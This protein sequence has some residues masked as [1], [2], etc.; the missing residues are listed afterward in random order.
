[1]QQVFRMYKGV[2]LITCQQ[3][4]ITGIPETAQQSTREMETVHTHV[5]LPRINGALLH[6]HVE[7]APLH[8]LFGD[9]AA[10]NRHSRHLFIGKDRY[11]LAGNGEIRSLMV[12][13]HEG[14]LRNR[15]RSLS[16]TYFLQQVLQD[17]FSIHVNPEN[18]AGHLPFIETG[19]IG[20]GRKSQHL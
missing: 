8:L 7:E 1:M 11:Y 20:F 10:Y 12:F 4:R 13:L 6:R 9:I 17:V 2:H 19:R 14:F 16:G 3:V 5:V 15:N 18:G